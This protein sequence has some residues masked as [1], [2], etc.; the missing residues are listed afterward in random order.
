MTEEQFNH[1]ERL[2]KRI[3][4]ESSKKQ[5]IV[6]FLEQ[7]EAKKIKERPGQTVDITCTEER[8][9]YEPSSIIS[10]NEERFENFLRDEIDQLNNKITELQDEFHNI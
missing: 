5:R 8:P 4:E 1:G 7:L 2:Q 3:N 6:T 10:V 9:R